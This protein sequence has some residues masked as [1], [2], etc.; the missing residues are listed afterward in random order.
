MTTKAYTQILSGKDFIRQ[1]KDADVRIRNAFDKRF[2]VFAKN[3]MDPHLNNHSLRDAW[4][5]YRSIDITADWRAIYKELT[6]G[7]ECIAYFIA[8]NT[9]KKLYRH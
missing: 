2:A 7:E 5:G 3:P 1:Y 4:Q 9:H 6:E 8:L